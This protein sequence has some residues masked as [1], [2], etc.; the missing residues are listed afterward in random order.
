MDADTVLH[1]KGT[2]ADGQPCQRTQF[3]TWGFC[4]QHINQM[5]EQES[6]DGEEV[7]LSS[8][9][10]NPLVAVESLLPRCSAQA[11]STGNRCK[12]LVSVEGQ[13]FCPAHGGLQIKP[14]GNRLAQCAAISKRS[15]RQCKNRIQVAG[16][17]MCAVH[18]GA[19]KFKANTIATEK[20]EEDNAALVCASIQSAC[21]FY[22][23]EV[24]PRLLC[25]CSARDPCAGLQM[26]QCFQR[27]SKLILSDAQQKK[28]CNNR[29]SVIIVQAESKA[30]L[31]LMPR[32]EHAAFAEL[33]TA[34]GMFGAKNVAM[35]A[36]AFECLQQRDHG[37]MEDDNNKDAFDSSSEVADNEPE[38]VGEEEE[39][40]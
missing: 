3:G 26:T 5:H 23:T 21:L 20:S 32:G 13:T 29:A 7:P 34:V 22:L 33:F 9:V 14:V 30:L 16:E 15:G 11:A 10:E 1:C 24:H 38:I 35:L 19:S 37:K 28:S 6:G 12:K 40:F 31:P 2:R 36:L 25:K 17:T 8:S 18:G 4:H 39:V 27:L